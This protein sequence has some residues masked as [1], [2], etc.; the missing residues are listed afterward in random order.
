[1]IYDHISSEIHFTA[2]SSQTHFPD[3]PS[4]AIYDDKLLD[5]MLVTTRANGMKRI[6]G[7]ILYQVGVI[8]N[9]LKLPFLT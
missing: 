2:V 7:V 5:F 8:S 9:T 6:N 1:M 3:L 4:F